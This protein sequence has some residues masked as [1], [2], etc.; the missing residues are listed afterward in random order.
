MG[1]PIRLT[2]ALAMRARDAA[3]IQDR[4]LTEQVEHWAR[5]GQL[6][7]SVATN[8]TVERLKAISHDP[9]LTRMLATADT[10]VGRA[11]AKRAI[12][13]ASPFRHG[14]TTASPTQIVKVEA[15]PRARR[16]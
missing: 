5:L 4:S 10:A 6:V 11:R 16:Q 7:E 3:A 13:H 15:K 14:T 1:F 2:T 8:A 12:A 9:G